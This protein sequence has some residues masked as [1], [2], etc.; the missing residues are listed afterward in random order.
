MK[1]WVIVLTYFLSTSL[2]AETN[3]QNLNLGAAVDTLGSAGFD[4]SSDS[5]TNVRSA[6]IMLYGPIDHVFDGMLN[7]AGHNHDGDFHFE[8]HEAYIGSS[9]LI[10]QSRFR[11]GKFLLGVGRLNN[12]HQHDWPFVT[13]PKVFR[14]FFNPGASILQAESVSDTG[15]EYSWLLPTSRY[16][17]VTLGVTNGYCYGDCD[18]PGQKPPFPLYYIHPTTFIDQGDGKGLLLGASFM[19]RKSAA[20]VKTD[21]FGFDATYKVREGKK[22]KWLLQSEVFYQ[23]QTVTDSDSSKK[24]GFYVYPQFGY[25]D[26]L[27]FGFRVDGFSHLNLKDSTSNEKLKDFDYALVPTMTYKTS[28]FS[29]VRLAYAHE[30]DT[31]QGK[32]N[33]MDRQIQLQL[34]FLLG[35]HP[36]H[37]F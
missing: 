28:E 30:V 20:G 23:V 9:K 13:A 3:L 17:D 11:V 5:Q 36:T 22:L 8:L 6:E 29:T 2:F 12:Y 4:K 31:T 34:T 35:A 37:E 25:N 16:V 10:P 24:L 15:L 33:V 1:R 14:E 21:L 26:R 7:V 27:S 18:T 19:G 32:D